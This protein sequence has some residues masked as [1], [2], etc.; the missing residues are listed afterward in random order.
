MIRANCR[1]GRSSS[2][3]QKRRQRKAAIKDPTVHRK[4]AYFFSLAVLAMLVI[5]IVMLFSTSAFAKD[6]HG[7]VYFFLKRQAVWLGVGLVV[8]T[9]C[10]PG[11]LPFLAA[12]LVDLV[13]SRRRHPGVV[14][15]AASRAAD[16]RFAPLGRLWQLEFQPSE[17]AKVAAVF[18]LACWYSH[19]EK[20][21]G[22][23]AAGLSH[24]AG[25]D[26]HFARSYRR[27]SG[28]RHD[29]THRRDDVRHD[30]RRRDQCQSC[31]ARFPRSGS[32]GILFVATRCRNGWGG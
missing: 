32:G 16:Q 7:D 6:S 30:V 18:F 11:R 27:R 9:D 21:S 4:S 14:F 29:R 10:G 17:I 20:A 2:C 28:P 1:S 31:S 26:R 5:G 12:D 22:R 25:R 3:R 8:C 13:R 23:I 24:S 15:C 19:Y